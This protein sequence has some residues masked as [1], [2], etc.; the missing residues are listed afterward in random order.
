MEKRTQKLVH[1]IYSEKASSTLKFL[2][3]VLHFFFFFWIFTYL[4]GLIRAYKFDYFWKI[5]T[6][7]VFYVINIKEIPTYT[8]LL[9]LAYTFINVIMVIR[10]HSLLGTPE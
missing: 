9:R 2:I 10:A 3:K 8:A 7:T 5:P 1:I 4:H 6:Q